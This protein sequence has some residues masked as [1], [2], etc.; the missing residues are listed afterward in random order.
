MREAELK[1]FQKVCANYRAIIE[2]QEQEIMYLKR[3]KRSLIKEAR[4]HA[5]SNKTTSR[6]A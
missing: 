5:T 3:C 6:K 4:K 1:H 2:R